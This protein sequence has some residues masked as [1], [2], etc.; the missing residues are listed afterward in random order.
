MFVVDTQFVVDTHCSAYLPVRI[1]QCVSTSAYLPVRIYKLRI[2][3][4]NNLCQI[5]FFCQIDI[6]YG[7][8]Q[9]HTFVHR[10]LEGFASHN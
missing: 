6:L 1:Y 7:I 5:Y 8:E 4:N 10:S 9:Y 2:Y 3:S